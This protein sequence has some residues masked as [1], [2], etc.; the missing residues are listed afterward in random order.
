MPVMTLNSIPLSY[1]F[2]KHE[3]LCSATA[4]EELFT[5]GKS[6]NN[7]PLKLIYALNTITNHQVVIVVPKRNFKRANARNLLKRRMRE[8]Y[9]LNKHHLDFL[10]QKYNLALLFTGRDAKDYATIETSVVFLINHLLTLMPK[11]E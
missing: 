9:R 4:I 10:A 6:K 8:A 11:Q 7:A 1:T 2:G 3:R 5:V